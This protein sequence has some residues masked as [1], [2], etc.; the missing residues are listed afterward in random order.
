MDLIFAF[1]LSFYEKTVSSSVPLK[2]S[3]AFKLI[4]AS[5]IDKV[6]QHS[7]DS[8]DFFF[9]VFSRFVFGHFNYKNFQKLLRVE[10]MSFVLLHGGLLR[11]EETVEND[12]L[13]V[14]ASEYT[15]NTEHT[16]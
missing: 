2:Q 7:V 14:D 6:L 9:A 1:Y 8:I 15:E 4:S 11:K 16:T 3:N 13:C 12:G 10:W 5:R